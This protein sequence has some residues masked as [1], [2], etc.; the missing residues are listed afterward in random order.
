MIERLKLMGSGNEEERNF[1]V[2]SK[3]NSFLSLFPIFLIGCG[4]K[5]I[6]MY[7]NYQNDKPN[8][9]N[10]KNKIEHFQNQTYDIDLVYTSDRIILIVRT[11]LKNR[12]ELLKGIKKLVEML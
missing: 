11:D 8:I 5:S 1:F 10:F 9:N 2:L 6:G 12:Q 3:G 7:E 4:F